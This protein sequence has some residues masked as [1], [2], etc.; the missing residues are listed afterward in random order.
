[1]HLF[2]R[3][4]T[5]ISNGQTGSLAR[6]LSPAVASLTDAFWCCFGVSNQEKRKLPGKLI[7]HGLPQIEGHPSEK[8]HVCSWQCCS[9]Q[10]GKRWW[11]DLSPS[12]E[13]ETRTGHLWPSWANRAKPSVTISKEL[14]CVSYC[15]SVQTQTKINK[16]LEWINRIEKLQCHFPKGPETLQLTNINVQTICDI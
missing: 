3:L 16:V 7:E 1:M 6:H 10:R 5:S 11:W 14:S 4:K 15:F 12:P 8:H 9:H 13:A 2:Q